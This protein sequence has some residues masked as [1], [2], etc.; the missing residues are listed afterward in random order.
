[1]EEEEE[2]EPGPLVISEAHENFTLDKKMEDDPTIGL[3]NP[4]HIICNFCEVILIPDRNAVKVAKEVNLIQNTQREYDLCSTY[5]HVDNLLK[6]Q[7]IEIHNLDEHMKYL[8]CLSCQSNI[9]GY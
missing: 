6:F 8:C 1:M 3:E 5:W 7:N 2:P 4:R 9:L